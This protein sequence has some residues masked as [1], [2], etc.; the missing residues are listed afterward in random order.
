MKHSTTL[1]GL[2]T[3]K[4]KIGPF[5]FGLC[6]YEACIYYAQ[7]KHPK[8]GH[9]CMLGHPSCLLGKLDWFLSWNILI[10][11][12]LLMG[13]WNSFVCK[14]LGHKPYIVPTPPKI[15]TKIVACKRC[16]KRFPDADR[17]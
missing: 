14:I 1:R 16:C 5:E 12:S 6:R 4:S 2:A 9:T 17:N 15:K 13:K 3:V 7:K 10:Y 11:G 8:T